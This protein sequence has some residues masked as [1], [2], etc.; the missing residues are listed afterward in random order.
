MKRSIAS[1][2]GFMA[3]V[4]CVSFLLVGPA[5]CIPLESDSPPEWLGGEPTE[6]TEVVETDQEASPIP[7]GSHHGKEV[8]MMGRSVMEG[9]FA[10]W[11]WDWEGPVS[12]NGYVLYYH[13]LPSPPDIGTDAAAQIAAVP[14]GTVVFFKL[15]FED[16]WA[17][18]AGEVDDNLAEILG[19][20]DQVLAAAEGRDVTIILG[21]ALPKVH[22][23]TTAPLVELHRAYNEALEERAT[24][25]DNVYVFDQYSILVDQNGALARGLATS[26]DDSHPNELAY[27]LMDEELFKLLDEITGGMEQ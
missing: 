12:R 23:E 19:Y 4:M 25:R 22:G 7:E 15:C 24:A 2:S 3:C 26:A 8:L 20:V 5:G 6:Q 16:F 14:D 13:N 11:D 21:N 1:I 9:L 18:D 17:S 27:S 10:Y